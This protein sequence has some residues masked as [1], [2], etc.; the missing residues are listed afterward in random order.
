MT[1]L[2]TNTGPRG[3]DNEATARVAAGRGPLL[4]WLHALRAPFFT[5]T[6]VPVLLGATIARGDLA[7]AGM[8]ASWDWNLLWL[9]VVGALAAHA[10]TNL[11]NDYG[12]H[13]TGNDAANRVPSRFNGGSRVIQA[14]LILPIRVLLASMLCFCLTVVIGLFINWK[15]AGSTF[16]ATPLLAIG[17]IGCLLGISYTLGPWRLGYRGLGE[18]SIALGF[19]PVMVLGS[20]YVLSAALPG[21][22]N[23]M[24]PLL[25]S[26]P[27]A[28]FALLII[29]INQF[30]DVPAD[31]MV[32]K[33]NWVVRCAVVRDGK[34]RYELPFGIYRLLGYFGFV[35]VVLLGI[36]GGIDTALGTLYALLALMPLPLMIYADRL[37]RAWL[38]DWNR[39]DADPQH[40]PYVLLRVNAITVLIHLSCGLLLVLAY[41]LRESV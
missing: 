18:L 16:A 8:T 13:L 36:A 23:W 7:R 11:A 25:A 29:W 14:G 35:T 4:L 6:L 27:V 28:M 1:S 22:W 34:I 33:R 38:R 26:L 15:L 12:D 3:Q 40:L 17:I 39:A 21:S 19:G 37:G 9:V 10:G 5:A 2:P 31:R 20:H 32:G 24:P 41:G 30:Q